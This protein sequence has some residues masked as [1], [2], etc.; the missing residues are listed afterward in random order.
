MPAIS[1]KNLIKTYVT[2]DTSIRA[3]N[4]T[5]LSVN[6][7]EFLILAGPSGCGKTTLISVI[8]G[9]L[10]FDQGE[11]II[12]GQN[13][14]ALNSKEILKFRG[15]NIGFVFQQFN[16]IP[17]ITVVE[18]III[19]LLINGYEYND[20]VDKGV[21]VLQQVGLENYA[22]SEPFNL[23]GGQQQRV[24]IARALVHNPKIIVCDE[25]TSALDSVNGRHVMSILKTLSQEHNR[26]LIVVTH[27]NRIYDFADR[28]ANMND[29]YIKQIDGEGN[30]H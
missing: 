22:N 27:D 21:H 9:I 4:D 19:P 13:L 14:K 2:G 18:N 8:A 6:E 26:T 16:L 5:T 29:G 10:D 30:A 15:E 24:A 17:T 23:S 12:L 28:V 3:L 1:C 25:P 11:C 20:A 7:G